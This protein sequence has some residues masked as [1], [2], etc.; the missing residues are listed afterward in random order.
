MEKWVLFID[1]DRDFLDTRSEF[2]KR[3]NYKVLTASSF[4]QAEAILQTQPVHLIITDLRLRNDNDAQDISGLTLARLPAYR[5]IPKI[6]LTRYPSF[7]YVREAL[8]RAVDDLPPAVDFL[9][10]KEGPHEMLKVVKIAFDHHV[11]VNFDLKIYWRTQHSLCLVTRL[12]E[13]DVETTQILER[14]KELDNLFRSL[15]YDSR[16]IVVTQLF[17]RQKGS[18]T[19]T[20][21][22][23]SD[24]EV[25]SHVLVN[26]APKPYSRQE[27]G[28]YKK[29]FGRSA[30]DRLEKVKEVESIHFGAIAFKPRGGELEEMKVLAQFY[31]ENSVERIITSLNHLFEASLPPLHSRGMRLDEPGP[32]NEFFA[33]WLDLDLVNLTAA[34]D[35]RI[36]SLCSRAL[37]LGLTI[38]DSPYNLVLRRTNGSS[39]LYPNPL[40]HL[41]TPRVLNPATYCGL[42]YGRVDGQGVL[43]DRAGQ[44]WL[45]DYGQV[46]QGPLLRD[47]V[48]LETV[49][50]FEL[51]NIP[52]VEVRLEIEQRLARVSHLS[53]QVETEDLEPEAQKAIKVI[54]F[55]RQKAA[56]WP[57]VNLDAYIAGLLFCT[58]GW[59]AGYEPQSLYTRHELLP[60]IQ[61]LLSLAIL[62]HKLTPRPPKDLPSQAW[63][64]IWLDQA[65]QEVWVEGKKIELAPAEYELLLILYSKPNDLRT[66]QDII[67]ELYK[68]DYGSETE[69]TLNTR[70]TRLRKKIEPNP[71]YP[72]YIETI[73]GRGYKLVIAGD[74]S[75]PVEAGK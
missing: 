19:L 49:I 28:N 16:Q 21:C 67:Q 54:T 73:R 75:S 30:N 34:L 32:L 24:D 1:N 18:V 20:I 39:V 45:I 51:L 71:K 14:E 59:L 6:I 38:D 7:K 74:D 46:N 3:D 25:E 42:T 43:V 65:N 11:K 55:I 47:F 13:P 70:M 26:C 64:S 35:G 57:G 61:A 31:K 9:D 44:T 56:A 48:T 2:L 29:I 72:K 37:A 8:G 58:A 52:S 60:Y 4:E 41:L 22:A 50:K 36:K 69:D 53:E 62:C 68:M 5:V 27:S 23:F 33:K 12:L 40:L 63:R 15:F 17:A 10:K 66:R